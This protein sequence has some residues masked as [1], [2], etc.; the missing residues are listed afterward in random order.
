MLRKNRK[1]GVRRFLLVCPWVC[2]V[3]VGMV[4][5]LYLSWDYCEELFGDISVVA[6]RASVVL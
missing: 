2:L 4:F 3:F 5:W 6:Y 1:I